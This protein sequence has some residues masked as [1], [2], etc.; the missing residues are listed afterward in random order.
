MLER[1]ALIRELRAQVGSLEAASGLSITTLSPVKIAD[2]RRLGACEPDQVQKQ[3]QKQQQQQQQLSAIAAAPRTDGRRL[4]SGRQVGGAAKGAS[5]LAGDDEHL[6]LSFDLPDEESSHGDTVPFIAT[7]C[8]PISA[9][10]TAAKVKARSSDADLQGKMGPGAELDMKPGTARGKAQGDVEE[11]LSGEDADVPAP[12]APPRPME[13]G[14]SAQPSPAKRSRAVE[15]DEDM[16]VRNSL[17]TLRESMS[18]KSAEALRSRV[19]GVGVWEGGWGLEDG[20]GESQGAMKTEEVED[21]GSAR[22]TELTRALG[23]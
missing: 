23:R 1:E 3:R 9:S 11:A 17:R 4:P 16:N 5:S 2:A 14:G 13:Q 10:A 22:L 19:A 12:R 6:Q 15:G 20:A 8:T 7:K 21:E 18:V